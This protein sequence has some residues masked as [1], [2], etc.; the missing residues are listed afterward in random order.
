MRKNLMKEAVMRL[1]E[2]NYKMEVN[3]IEKILDTYFSETFL[4]GWYFQSHNAEEIADHIY[5]ATQLLNAGTEYLEH[6][7][8]DGKAITYFLNVGQDFPGKLAGIIRENKDMGIVT[9][10]SV[11]TRSG[12]R[13]I[14]IER[15]GRPVGDLTGQEQLLIGNLKRDVKAFGSANKYAHTDDFILT[16]PGTYMKQ[17]IQGYTFPSRIHR[18]LGVFEKVLT[19]GRTFIDIE[20]STQDI[21]DEKLEGV[22]KRIILGLRNPNTEAIL[23]ALFVFENLGVNLRRSYYDI[24][25]HEG[26]N[27]SVGILS[28]YVKADVK[29]D[30]IKESLG[31]IDTKEPKVRTGERHEVESGL[32][33]II[34]N[35]SSD[36]LT[37]ESLK[38][39]IGELKRFIARNGDVNEKSELNIFL[40]NAMTDLMEAAALLGLRDNARLLHLLLRFDSFDE[41][42]VERKLD[43]TI[44]NTEGFRTKH[45]SARGT[46]KGGLRIDNIVEFAEVSALAFMMTWKCARSKILFG[47]GKG[48]LKIN[49]GDFKGKKLDFFNTLA[50]FGRYLF[51]VT[52][53]LKDVPAGDVGCGPLEI[54]HMFEGF[55][56]TLHDLSKM[57]YGYKEK[58]SFI[59]NTVI[60]MEYARHLLS[61]NF[62]IDHM[63][64]ELVKELATNEKYLELVAAAQITG[65]PFMGIAARGAATGLGLC[66]SVLAAV[67]KLFLEGNWRPELP[68]TDSE[69]E[70]LKKTADIRE[71]TLLKKNGMDIISDGDWEKL[72]SI[73]G[74][75]LKNKTVIVQGSGKVGGSTIDELKMFGINV[76]AM[77]DKEG[78]IIGD[79]LDI[80]ELLAA[81]KK[82]GTVINVKKN[83]TEKVCGAAEGTVILEKPCDIL[84][85]AALENTITVFNADKIKAKL[86]VCG[87]NGPST[88]KAE[89]ILYRNGIAVVYDFL[90][91]GGGVTVSYF[92][93]LRNLAE[94]FRYEAEII[95]KRAF[96][97]DIM[98]PYIMPEFNKRIKNIL[99]REESDEI[100]REWNMLLRDIVFSAV[101][102]DYDEA[103]AA[104][105]SMKTI[106]FAN[107][108]LRVLTASLLKMP[109]ENRLD[110]W[111]IIPEDTKKRLKPFFSHP[112]T[113]I[114]NVAAAT[115]RETLYHPS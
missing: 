38:K 6:V 107:A 49:P 73:Y 67:T 64:K 16:L 26:M 17:E 33:R 94:R 80:E 66:Y 99:V 1:M 69:K 58:A 45:N 52:G 106:G 42:W 5:I 15:K 88:S 27:A 34:R 37:E 79:H 12:I 4:P 101:N 48:G 115:I 32:E 24:F 56:S 60:S 2:S 9:Y 97:I 105:V 31:R 84:I 90:A 89:T 63:D 25:T 22:E 7:S 104:G 96:D 108:I 77:A 78:A 29:T 59:G 81:A 70:L 113:L 85:P 53:P 76:T 13:L 68:I 98:D 110:Y 93:W 43:G 72:K 35:L 21:D 11:K 74:K 14:D 91:N 46:N 10:D 86:I 103:R 3:T 100:T 95:H 71:S 83:V 82:E 19:T 54:G 40:L 50:N 114:H 36:A 111:R 23:E 109:E 44:K 20:D 47:G 112:E 65:K 18:H 75:L 102:E 8:S 55:K 57:V 30:P 61:E 62:H 28:F 51:L 41:F 39:D 92:E 87:S